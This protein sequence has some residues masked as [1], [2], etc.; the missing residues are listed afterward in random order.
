M[1][2][3]T[4]NQMVRSRSDGRPPRGEGRGAVRALR[5][6]T[7]AR[8]GDKAGGHGEGNH[9][10]DWMVHRMDDAPPGYEPPPGDIASPCW[11][12]PAR[13]PKDDGDWAYE[14]KWDGIRAIGHVDGGRI[15][16]TSRNG[17]DLST[18]FP[19]LRSLG[20]HLGSHQVVIDGEIVA[21]DD[22]GRPRFQR[23]QPRIH[24]A[25][26][27]KAK[28]LAAVQPG[29]VRDLRSSVCRRSVARGRDLRRA[30]AS[31][32]RLSAST[33]PKGS[34]WTVSPRFAGPGSDILKASQDQ[35]LEGVVAK[36]LDAPYLPGRRSSTW[37]KV[38]N[39][40]MQD[41]VIGGWTPGEGHRAGRF[42]SL[43]LGIPSDG[44]LQYV[45]QVG[46]GLQRRRARR[47]VAR[48]WT[49][50]GLTIRAPSP[51][52]SPVGTATCRRGCNR[53]WWAK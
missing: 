3:P 28:R 29:G 24:A 2:A 43:L 11:P 51:P 16:I 37:T 4:T 23:L 27:A 45:G 44:G 22:K 14:F 39:I 8:A 38:K 6:G 10:R 5:H 49:S 34:S 40:L 18:S 20:E 9:R 46:H 41:V 7:R 19:E 31:T 42:G 36:R 30:T 15:R 1:S 33:R 48:H 12:W 26:A 50:S 47:S 32:R 13:C 35:G 52:R 53:D 17:N 21:F 25:D